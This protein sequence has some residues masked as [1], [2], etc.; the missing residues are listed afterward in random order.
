MRATDLLLSVAL[1]LMTLIASTSADIARE[2]KTD[3]NYIVDRQEMP[4]D[5]APGAVIL[6]AVFVP[7]FVLALLG[8]MA[9]NPMKLSIVLSLLAAVALLVVGIA[10]W[11]A[12]YN[13]TR[14]IIQKRTE[15]VL[16]R[17]AEIT[18]RYI[19]RE[20]SDGLKVLAFMVNQIKS[21][22][23]DMNKVYPV[24]YANLALIF[25]SFGTPE[26]VEL[27]YY[28]VPGHADAMQIGGPGLIGIGL[29]KL[30]DDIFSLWYAS[31][32]GDD[33]AE[34][35]TCKPHD[36]PPHNDET[37]NVCGSYAC[38]T[39]ATMD[40]VCQK[41]CAGKNGVPDAH[42]TYC[43]DYHD[44]PRRLGFFQGQYKPE[45]GGSFQA[46]QPA[47]Y[48]VL[49]NFVYNPMVRPWWTENPKFT[50]SSP[51][52]FV[53]DTFGVGITFS[54]G[55]YDEANKFV[56]CLAVDFSL[57]SIGPLLSSLQPTPNTDM[58][59]AGVDG[60]L[61]GTTMSPEELS[62]DTGLVA[63][64]VTFITQIPKADSQ[65]KRAFG[66]ITSR[67]GG[68]IENATAYTST[69][70]AGSRIYMSRPIG[71]A[72]AG[73]TYTKYLLVLELPYSDAM[74]TA[75][76]A[77][78]FSLLLT[79]IIAVVMSGIV[80][81]FVT[82]MLT[83]LRQLAADM[84]DVACM[85]LE[86]PTVSS[87]V[88][89]V[90]GMQVSFQIMVEKLIEYREYLPQSV[91]M[92]DA[93]EDEVELDD[94]TKIKSATR[95]ATTRSSM[96]SRTHKTSIA[97]AQEKTAFVMELK[98]KSSS[99]LVC[100]GVNFHE[101]C[102]STKNKSEVIEGHALYV[103]TVAEAA[104]LHKGIVE[105]FS[106]DKVSIG[107]NTVVSLSTH[108]VAALTTG[109]AIVRN[110]A[111]LP[112]K[113]NT[114]C[115]TGKVHV[116]NMGTTGLKKFNIIGSMASNVR[117]YERLGKAWEL[118]LVASSAI[119]KDMAA[120]FEYRMLYPTTSAGV[121]HAAFE[122]LAECKMSDKE[123]MYQLEQAATDACYATINRACELFFAGDVS[124]ALS[125]ARTD[126]TCYQ[127]TLT[128][129]IEKNVVPTPL[130]LGEGSA[131]V[132]A[133]PYLTQKN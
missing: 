99:L 119:L 53:G 46:S 37:N 125:A 31:D 71:A 107:F 69:I 98:T 62:A 13:E 115:S 24:A 110:V 96:G 112:F 16:D 59:I 123:W 9:P 94:L 75:D 77:S 109:L 21:N 36:R 114:A 57:A 14:D 117:L 6:I 63:D 74:G 87:R 127:A 88:A 82:V 52:L 61:I 122:V 58:H 64:D 89:E 56:A 23:I 30:P 3:Q 84:F 90:K 128:A 78:F 27:I 12:T 76:D 111:K 29:P 60:A 101:F 81:G 68:T 42:W 133:L 8:S 26:S 34:F 66:V 2:E 15:Q 48:P 20:M 55:A 11:A 19:E 1:L 38:G 86:V 28:G 126:K 130:P 49:D 97:K 22:Q 102:T 100:N 105:G 79:I 25:K 124:E 85:K 54:A 17:A 10:S 113:V 132:E 33:F 70:H 7:L 45:G 51:Y 40:Y 44:E 91:L 93:E 41:T 72:L 116:G 92:A 118:G 47:P 103:A 129:W 39:N 43:Q 32:Y 18:V 4:D 83:P 131:V 65:V 67:Y 80:C 5:M 73:T 108:K 106:G 50:I 121:K 104:K 95:S 120:N 35:V